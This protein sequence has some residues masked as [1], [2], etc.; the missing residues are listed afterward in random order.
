MQTA[1][2]KTQIVNIRAKVRRNATADGHGHK[3][4]V[5]LEF[6]TS[7]QLSKQFNVHGP[8]YRNNILIYIQQDAMLHSLIA[9]FIPSHAHI[10]T[11]KH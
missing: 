6:G 1:Y 4:T 7:N 10:Q 2:R 11:S 5:H 8:M 3:I 9:A